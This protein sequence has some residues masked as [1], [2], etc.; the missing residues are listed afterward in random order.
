MSKRFQ[1]YDSL[2]RS[3]KSKN[4]KPVA[5]PTEI[6]EASRK[7]RR[8]KPFVYKK[9]QE[10]DK[11]IT[12]SLKPTK[13]AKDDPNFEE[14]DRM[15]ETTPTNLPP[16]QFSALPHSILEGNLESSKTE[17][18]QEKYK[19]TKFPVSKSRK[20]LKKRIE[21]FLDIIPKILAGDEELSFHYTL[22]LHQRK[23][24]NH[25]TM[26]LEERWDIDWEQYVG[27]YYGLKRQLFIS[28]L[29]HNKHKN[30]L[31]R[32][33]NKTILYWTPDMFCTYV[34]ANEIILRLVMDDMKLK[35][36]E[37]ERL[38][39]DTVD[40]GVHVADNEEFEDDLEFGELF[41]G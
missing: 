35:K 14:L 17:K 9:P 19:K 33:T 29:V 18:V 37:A 36:V 24:S 4:V 1:P 30:L 22:A 16:S 15:L 31:S 23:K 34:L 40:Y 32:S 6:F 12:V 5:L 13:T 11:L 27:G 2:D 21:P 38:M 25:S 7:P 26:T 41:Q 3:K 28:T 39:R 10:E 20:S 8:K